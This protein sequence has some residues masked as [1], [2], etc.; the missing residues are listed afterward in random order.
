VVLECPADR[1]FETSWE[2]IPFRLRQSANL[3][4][5][6]KLLNVPHLVPLTE[7]AGPFA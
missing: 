6:E 1:V 2:S 5:V 3:C 7:V 4:R